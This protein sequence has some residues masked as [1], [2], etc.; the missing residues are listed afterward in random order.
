MKFAA[1]RFAGHFAK[2]AGKSAR[3]IVGD[4]AV[5]ARV[6]RFKQKVG[7]FFLSDGIP[8]LHR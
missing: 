4:E 1:A 3:A 7:H 6:P 5:K 2:A 8:D